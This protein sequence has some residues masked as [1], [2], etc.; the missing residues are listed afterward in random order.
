MHVIKTQFTGDGS[1]NGVARLEVRPCQQW[2]IT[3][4]AVEEDPCMVVEDTAHAPDAFEFEMQWFTKTQYAKPH[5]IVIFP[6]ELARLN[7]DRSVLI[8]PFSGIN[9]QDRSTCRTIIL[10]INAGAFMIIQNLIVSGNALAGLRAEKV[11][12]ILFME[13]MILVEFDDLTGTESD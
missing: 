1:R 2:Q 10:L 6:G 9:F 3:Y 4:I 13:K 8:Q 12:C 11:I 7:P 5:R